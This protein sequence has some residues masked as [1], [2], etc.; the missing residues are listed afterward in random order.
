ML[1]WFSGFGTKCAMYSV[2]S[3]KEFQA[4]TCYLVRLICNF[5]KILIFPCDGYQRVEYTG[6]EGL[7]HDTRAPLSLAFLTAHHNQTFF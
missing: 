3:F 7:F 6:M 5:H 2:V 1:D 4:K